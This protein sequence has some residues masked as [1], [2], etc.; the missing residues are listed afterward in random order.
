M[1]FSEIEQGLRLKNVIVNKIVTIRAFDP[2]SESSATIFYS[3]ESGELG[4]KIVTSE[5]VRAYEVVTTGRWSFTADGEEF[6]LASEARRVSWAHLFDP[7]TAVDSAA[8]DPLPHQIEAVYEQMLTKQPLKYL[9]ADDPGAGKTIMSGLLMLELRLRGDLSRCL[10]VAPGSLVE[11]WQ[12]ELYEKFNLSFEIMSRSMVEDARSGN[13]FLEKNLLIARLD[14]I[15]RSEDLLEKL[16]IADWDLVIVDEA[17]KMSAHRYGRKV[18]KTKR[19]QLGETLR[20]RTRNFL[21]LTATPHN[22]KPDDFLLFMQLLDSERFEGRVRGEGDIDTGG[23]MRRYVKEN[24]LRFDGTRLFPQRFST[25]LK[26]ELSDIENDLYEN[27]SDY[28]RTGMNQAAKM[29]ESGDRRGT[30]VGFAL[31]GLQRRLASSPS[32]IH[33]SLERRHKKLLDKAE[34]WAQIVADGGTITIS[35]LPGGVRLQDLEDFDYEDWSDEELEDIEIMI[36]GE[37]AAGTLKE[38]EIEARVVGDLVEKAYRVLHSGED[39]KW[40]ELREVLR[41]EDFQ[42][43]DIPKKLIVF[44]EHKDTLSYVADRIRQ[45]LGRP[46]AVVEIHGGVKREDRRKIQENFRTDPQVRI[47]VATDAAGEGVNLQ[48][49]NM[50]VNY[51]LPWNPNRIEQRFGRVHRIGQELPCYLWNLVA[52]QTREGKVFERLFTK[53]EQQRSAYGDQVYDVLGDAKINAS[54]KD[55]LNRAIRDEDDPR[56][57]EYLEEVIDKDIGQQLTDVLEE[58]SLAGLGIGDVS[59]EIK[60]QMERAKARKLQPGFI[61]SFFVGALKRFGGRIRERE[62]K[63]FE[64][65][66]VPAIFRNID[67]L[68][69]LGVIVHEKY[70]RVTFHKEAVDGER[71]VRADLIAPG[72]PLLSSLVDIIDTKFSGSLSEG[73]LLVDPLDM[74]QVPRMLVYLEHAIADGRD[75]NG[76]KRVVSRRFQFVE[77]DQSG[78]INDPGTQPYLNYSSLTEEEDASVRNQ[79]D[80]AWADRTTE[81][82]SKN[83]AIDNLAQPHFKEIQLLTNDRVDRVRAAVKERLESEINYWIVTTEE[84]KER[85]LQGR[86]VSPTS[87]TCRQRHEDLAVRLDVRNRELDKE[88]DLQN[89]PP[90]VTSA[91]IVIPQGLL[92][93]LQGDTPVDHDPEI[94]AETDRRAVAAV[95][96]AETELGRKPE[97]QEHNNPGFDVLS[98]DPETGKHFY[99]EVKGYLP[100]TTEIKI[101]STQVTLGLNNPDCFR[102]VAV[103][104]PDD[105]EE[106]PLPHYFVEP[107]DTPLN[108]AQTYL[109]L[110]VSTLLELREDP[111]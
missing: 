107:F 100:R 79:L 44:T 63:R 52:Y 89:Q 99:I 82:I 98:I 111:V 62:T 13:P 58:R 22:G 28:V 11:Q 35:D 34:S 27:V 88:K 7:F 14:Q 55:L 56:H 103:A 46:E 67:Q 12:D 102:L 83:W 97:E 15:S 60:E 5:E 31:T 93:S 85:E 76:R 42:D 70:E 105:P 24:L 86:K 2:V 75:D 95:M 36:D 51:D 8:I 77:I 106:E 30:A 48:R 53:I 20:E 18:E 72:H 47:L 73:A 41:S 21:L 4:Q 71:V 91:A 3:D 1:D 80:V 16:K 37:T 92:D 69:K 94:K 49:A 64:I 39:K 38:L 23:V 6:R 33:T 19:Y 59:D 66:R 109:P 54:L 65:T 108:F 57:R 17:H 101:S 25:T 96:K 68:A 9:L 84:T 78:N 50:V 10:I 104:V 32:A 87:G 26:F 74:G 40:N 61:Q 110:K 45:E 81:D 90:V 43:G 29:I